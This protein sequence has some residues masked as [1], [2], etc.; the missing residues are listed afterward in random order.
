MMKPAMPAAPTAI[1]PRRTV[2][3]APSSAPKSIPRRTRNRPRAVTP[4]F[5]SEL[6]VKPAT[7]CPATP[8]APA[9][10]PAPAPAPAVSP[11]PAAGAP[12]GNPVAAL[13]APPAVKPPTTLVAARARRYELRDGTPEPVLTLERAC[14]SAWEHAPAVHCTP[15]QRETL[16]AALAHA[17]LLAPSVP[18]SE[19]DLYC[20]RLRAGTALAL[21]RGEIASAPGGTLRAQPAHV[22]PHL[23]RHTRPVLNAGCVDRKCGF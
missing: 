3:N 22:V 4:S 15:M 6:R 23:A 14:A 12:Q 21:A 19:A 8:P 20:L 9:T 1:Q 10:E 2:R 18:P 13:V 11:Q 16:A 17:S 5:S 7:R